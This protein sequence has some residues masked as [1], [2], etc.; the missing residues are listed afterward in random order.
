MGIDQ[1]EKLRQIVGQKNRKNII[2]VISAKGGVGKTYLTKALYNYFDNSFIVECD[3]NSPYFWMYKNKFKCK[4]AEEDL[5]DNIFKEYDCII[6][7]SGT[8]INNNNSEYIQKSNLSI[9][10]LNS[11]DICIANNIKLSLK[12]HNKKIFYVNNFKNE[13]VRYLKNKVLE[14][15]NLYI[16]E[17]IQIFYNLEDLIKYIKFYSH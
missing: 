15:A 13:N 5:S 12:L 11:D 14:I 1:A 4:T 2:S 7:D 9:I 3:K 6:I 8:N 17:D 10:V 16:K